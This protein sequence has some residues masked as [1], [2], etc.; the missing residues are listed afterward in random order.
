MD[1]EIYVLSSFL[2]I[3]RIQS[4]RKIIALVATLVVVVFVTHQV[5]GH[6]VK[7]KNIDQATHEEE[8]VEVIQLLEE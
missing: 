2:L 8:E 1:E 7:R 4:V 6:H 5:E 3:H